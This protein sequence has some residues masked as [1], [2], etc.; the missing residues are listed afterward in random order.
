M[1]TRHMEK[2]KSDAGVIGEEETTPKPTVMKV[3]HTACH[4]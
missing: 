3:S 1:K 2:N 4:W